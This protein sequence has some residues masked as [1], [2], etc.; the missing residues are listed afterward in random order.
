MV[1]HNNVVCIFLW[2]QE[3]IQPNR[4]KEAIVKHSWRIADSVQVVERI[5]VETL[6]HVR[7]KLRQEWLVQELDRDDDILQAWRG[8]FLLD[9]L[10]YCLC[11]AE[12]LGITPARGRCLV[13]AVIEAI[14]R[15]GCAVEIDNDLES[16]QP[17]PVDSPV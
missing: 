6:D 1:V 9:D 2:R 10:K 14:L 12:T 3:T 4:I 17:G 7:V 11:V 13:A 15:L 8:V 5:A 16:C